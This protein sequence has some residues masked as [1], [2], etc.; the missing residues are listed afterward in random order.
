MKVRQTYECK[1]DSITIQFTYNKDKLIT[2][3]KEVDIDLET[4]NDE[5]IM[6][7]VNITAEFF[8]K[9]INNQRLK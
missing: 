4:E 9:I 7:N 5:L 6:P 8:N 2:E 3:F 1:N